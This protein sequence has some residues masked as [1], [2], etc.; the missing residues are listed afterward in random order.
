MIAWPFNKLLGRVVAK[1]LNPIEGL[2]LRTLFWLCCSTVHG[3]RDKSPVE[4]R[5]GIGHFLSSRKGDTCRAGAFSAKA[6]HPCGLASLAV[7]LDNTAS[8]LGKN[9]GR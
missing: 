5:D 6:F 7:G 3:L 2:R 8:G 1:S 9:N 4:H